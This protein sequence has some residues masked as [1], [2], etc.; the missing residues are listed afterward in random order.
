[1]KASARQSFDA[2]RTFGAKV[3][4]GRAAADYRS[5][6]AGFPPEFFARFAD[7]VG[8]VH[9][10]AALDLGTGTGTIARGLAL[11]GLNVTGVDPSQPLLNEAKAMDHLAGV[12]VSYKR[13]RAED[14]PF[15]SSSF[16]LVIAGQCWHWFDRAAGAAEALRVL[17]P[18]GIISVAH[19]DWLPLPGNVVELTERLILDANPAWTMGGGAGIY[20]QWAMDLATAGFTNLE[21]RSFDIDQVYSH[22]A[23]RGRIRASAGIRASLDE[24]DTARFDAILEARLQEHFPD[25]P[26]T[27]PHRVWWICGQ[28]PNG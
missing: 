27:V 7:H 18:G 4:F 5:F 12:E 11:L 3:D 26:I 20:P 8:F 1:M 21:T 2:T 24:A 13:G 22:E 10:Q 16:D 17:K 14:L 25:D 28:K 15:P 9:R 6:R 23:W 19:F